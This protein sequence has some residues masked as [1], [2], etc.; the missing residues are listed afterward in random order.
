MKYKAVIFDLDGTL[1]NTLEDLADAVNAALTKNGMPAR[2]IGEVREFVGNGI[3]RLIERAVP[4]GTAPAVREQVLQEFRV[5]YKEH[6]RDKTAPYSAILEMLDRLHQA[7]LKMAVVSNKAEF[8]VKE[9][10]PVYFGDRIMSVRGENEAAGIQKKP[11]PDMVYMALKECGCPPE[12]AVYV[13][14]SEVDLKTAAN[15]GL[16][17]ISVT[18]GFRQREWLIQ[19]GARILAESPEELCNKI[20][21]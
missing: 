8:A 3:G 21:E 9:L 6:C 14:D 10:V 17:C 16:D 11:A 4:E 20:M 18:W 19:H 7:G 13:G 12:K 15:V 5:H 2:G 1:L